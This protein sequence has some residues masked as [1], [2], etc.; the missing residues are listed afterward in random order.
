MQ[1]DIGLKNIYL[2]SIRWHHLIDDIC[3]V[4]DS[5]Y[6]SK[7]SQA[8]AS[9]LP[10][11]LKLPLRAGIMLGYSRMRETQIGEGIRRLTAVF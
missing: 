5:S 2:H 4:S 11:F 8:S 9:N 1:I 6:E 7:P 3:N 10:D